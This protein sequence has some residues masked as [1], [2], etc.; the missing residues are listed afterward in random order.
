MAGP[1]ADSMFPR[2]AFSMLSYF[3]NCTETGAGAATGGGAAG[4]VTGASEIFRASFLESTAVTKHPTPSGA[5]VPVLVPMVVAAIVRSDRPQRSSSR[6]KPKP[7]STYPAPPQRSFDLGAVTP[8]IL[9]QIADHL[10][11]SD[12]LRLLLTCR[13]IHTLLTPHLLRL[14]L[15]TRL[16]H[17]GNTILHWACTHGHLTLARTLLSR[18]L[19]S[20]VRNA[21]GWTPLHLSLRHRHPLITS[22][23]LSS[24]ASVT[25]TCSGNADDAGAT[26]LH[27]AAD[28][29]AALQL[30]THGACVS[31][32][33]KVGL[34]PLHRACRRGAG[35]V[36]DVL[37]AHGAREGARGRDGFGQSP[38]EYAIASGRVELVCGQSGREGDR[39]VF[40]RAWRA[41]ELA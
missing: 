6:P 12:I 5:A 14:A 13:D 16:P 18:G 2:L 23:L 33:T 3:N 10:A 41:G 20:S 17:T 25:A 37:L 4:A 31:A 22:L 35:D 24:G 7:L 36:V 32:R 39:E 34:T 15:T 21:A 9:L 38:L 11:A 40:T 8:E 26:P 27:L 29:A 30:L 28:G 19:P 1:G